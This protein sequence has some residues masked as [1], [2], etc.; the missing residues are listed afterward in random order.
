M[1]RIFT[2]PVNE[3]FEKT[4]E[5]QACVC[6]FCLL[7]ADLEKNETDLILGGSMM[8]PDTR[9]KTNEMGFC[10]RHL[11][12]MMSMNRKLPLALM[13]ESRLGY[14]KEAIKPPKIPAFSSS[15]MV[16]KLDETVH[17]CYL[18]SRVDGNL[19]QMIET[20][21]L[22]WQSESAFRDKV[23]LQHHFCL[24]HYSEFLQDAKQRLSGK[25]FSEFLKTVGQKEYDYVESLGDNIGQ[26]CQMFDYRNEGEPAPEVKAAPVAA[27]EF[28][29]GKEPE[30]TT[31]NA[32]V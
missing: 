21:A 20:A 7:K 1:E 28:L 31:N 29:V 23:M 17:S 5:T 27:I 32:N 14:I 4:I 3:A 9:A 25:E 2:I 8:E 26:F 6:P 24:K 10:E 16:K 30:E 12:K 18:C 11:G 15:S 13:I 19:S 22:L